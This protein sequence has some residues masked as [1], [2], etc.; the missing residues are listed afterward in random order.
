MEQARAL[1]GGAGGS[2]VVGAHGGCGVEDCGSVP[3][4]LT[5]HLS[6]LWHCSSHPR[7]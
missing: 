4:S 6:F 2:G 7:F 3:P 1:A 5:K